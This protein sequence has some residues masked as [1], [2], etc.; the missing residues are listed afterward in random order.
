MAAIPMLLHDCDTHVIT[1]LW[2][3]CHYMTAMPM[4]WLYDYDVH[5][6]VAA[7]P[8]SLHDCDARVITWLR[9][10]CHYMIM[11]PMPLYGY[12]AHIIV[13]MCFFWLIRKVCR[14]RKIIRALTTHLYNMLSTASNQ[15]NVSFITFNKLWARIA[16]HSFNY[17]SLFSLTCWLIN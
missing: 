2:W 4:S 1:W 3:P 6:Y 5:H 7:V 13:E 14:E 10:S 11:M 12:D 8:I 9:C 16:G 17:L 15:P